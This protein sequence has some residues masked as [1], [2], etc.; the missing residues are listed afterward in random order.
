MINKIKIIYNNVK[1]FIP[2]LFKVNPFIVLFIILD[3]IFTAITNLFKLFFTQQLI[4]YLIEQRKPNEIIKFI[5]FYGLIFLLINIFSTILN[6]LNQNFAQKATFKIEEI[7]NDKISKIDYSLIEDPVFCDKISYAKKS[8]FEY[9]EGIYSII[10]TICNVLSNIITI[11]GIFSIVLVTKGLY[12]IILCIMCLII[13]G[14]LYSKQQKINESYNSS[15]VRL[16]RKQSFYN[17]SIYSFEYQKILRLFNNHKVINEKCYELN[18]SVFNESRKLYR[19]I[20]I[21]ECYGHITN[22][23]LKKCLM[24]I[25]LLFSFLNKNIE[26]ATLILLY[27]SISVFDDAS[28]QLVYT[29]KQ[30]LTDCVYQKNFID[31]MSERIEYTNGTKSICKIDTIEFRDVSFKYPRTEKYVLENF[32]LKFTSNEIVSFVGKNGS[33]KTTAIKLLCRLYNP[34]KGVILVNGININEYIYSEYINKLSTIF[35]DYKIMSFSIKDNICF[36]D[37]DEEKLKLVFK[38]LNLCDFINNLP[39]KELTYVNKWFDKKGIQFSTG[40]LQKIA[41]FRALYKKSDVII[42][43]EPTSALDPISEFKIYNSIRNLIDN[44]CSIFISHRLASCRFC[45]K[46]F[47]FDN[48]VVVEEGNHEELMKN[49]KLYKKMFSKQAENYKY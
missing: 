49:N 40:E 3:S 48:G 6:I 46:I 4:E 8:L 28:T 32:N 19:K 31:F 34:D 7:F 26:I 13:N 43:D 27:N 10:N 20:T 2:L 30:Y 23:I 35:Q 33:G 38:K 25:L 16:S 12:I 39:N 36:N 45:D 24:L 18:N 22:Y 15:M 14:L 47:V 9:S 5:I 17:K 21:L 29:L 11:I 41:F 1:F 37:Y 42:L 44:R